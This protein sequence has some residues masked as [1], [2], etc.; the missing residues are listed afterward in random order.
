MA[1]WTPTPRG[2]VIGLALAH[3]IRRAGERLR[4]A[5]FVEYGFRRSERERLRRSF[6]PLER[7]DSL[8]PGKVSRA[9][10]RHVYPLV[11]VQA[12]YIEC[13]PDGILW[14]VSPWS[15]RR[16]QGVTEAESA[17]VFPRSTQP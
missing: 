6:V 14:R 9:D 8:L 4:F 10:L 3:P 15:H 1:G 13:Q 7:P 11:T 17:G 2:N 16:R 12:R 5:A